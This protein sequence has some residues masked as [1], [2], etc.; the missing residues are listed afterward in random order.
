MNT[1]KEVTVET[2][3]S[4]EEANTLRYAAGYICKKVESK[5]KASTHPMKDKLILCLM[6]LCD[7]DEEVTNTSDWINAIDRGGLVRISENTF[8]FFQTMELVLRCVYNTKT[9][10]EMTNATREK[11]CR[12]ITANDD[13]LFY[14]CMVTVEVDQEEANTLLE[15]IVNLWITVRGYSFANSWWRCINKQKRNQHRNPKHS[16]VTF[17]VTIKIFVTEYIYV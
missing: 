1:D 11:L 17:L 12:L 4:Y 2:S 16:D 9:V 10:Q 7:E 5:I 13:V 8:Q 3:L 6:D 14:W 15:I